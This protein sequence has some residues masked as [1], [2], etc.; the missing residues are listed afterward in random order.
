MM[1]NMSTQRR[2]ADL[3]RLPKMKVKYKKRW[4]KAL[5]SGEY[6]QTTGSL[7]DDEGAFCC[8]GV[9]CDILKDEVDDLEIDSRFALP[10]VKVWKL[11]LKKESLE[12]LGDDLSLMDEGGNWEEEQ[13]PLSVTPLVVRNDGSGAYEGRPQSFKRIANLIE[14]CM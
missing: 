6:S 11:V 2:A 3:K 10:P 8:L 13:L 14:R 9:L 7:T 1:S 5:R 12:I 4:L